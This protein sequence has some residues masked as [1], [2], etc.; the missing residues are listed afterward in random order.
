[1]ATEELKRSSGKK[2]RE[3]CH[4]LRLARTGRESGPE[5]AALVARMGRDRAVLRLEAAAKR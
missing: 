4:P 3:L 1:M 2:G 5:M